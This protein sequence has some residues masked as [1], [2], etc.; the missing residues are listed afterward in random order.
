MIAG[1]GAVGSVLL[2]GANGMLGRAWRQ[3]LDLR[4]IDHIDL[5][6]PQFDITD[7]DQ[8]N[9][10]ID[11]SHTHVINCAAYTAVDDVE[12][13]EQIATRINGEAPAFLAARLRITTR[14]SSSRTVA[15]L[16]SCPRSSGLRAASKTSRPSIGS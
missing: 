2:L 6:L 1:G 10:S 7:P 4:G 5:D 16:L 11:G 3:L 15:T 13:N 12:A 14:L 8:V 9:A